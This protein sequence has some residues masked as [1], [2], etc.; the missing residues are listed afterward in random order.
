[1][2]RITLLATFYFLIAIG[3]A[4]NNDS[5]PEK[6]RR[7]TIRIGGLLIIT[8]KDKNNK[9][10][11]VD[12]RDEADSTGKKKGYSINS[13][14][15]RKNKKKR[16]NVSTNWISFDFGFNNYK[17]ETAYGTSGVNSILR[18]TSSMNGA[19]TANDLKVSTG[20][21]IAFNFWIVQ[22]KLNLIK[23]VIGLK[24]GLGLEINNYRFKS[25]TTY[26]DASPSY[27]I[28]DSVSFSKNK[29]VT[30]YLTVPLM[31][32]INP[33]GKGGFSISGGISAGYRY[34]AH[35]KQ[36]S[37]ARGKDKEFGD[38][39]LN[40]FKVALVGDIGYNKYRIFGS[41]NL[42]KMHD[43]ALNFTPYTIGIRLSSW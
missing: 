29:L 20:K 42:T 32:T 39:D 4:Q 15:L 11:E 21:S 41:Y 43:N 18:S 12:I 17:D 34:R 10:K 3:F 14:S 13:S 36:K 35:T 7:D 9:P 8:K 5:I 30:N 16:S 33:S 37:D 38:F 6:G 25:P 24:Y 22:Q 31:L 28:K 2:K 1:M 40:P 26:I 19:P 27:I 23:H